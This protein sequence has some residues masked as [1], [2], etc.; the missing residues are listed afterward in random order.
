MERTGQ[1][2][3][4]PSTSGPTGPESPVGPP[5]HRGDLHPGAGPGGPV[6]V[7]RPWYRRLAWVWVLVGGVAAYLAELVMLVGTGNPNFFPSLLLL[8]ALVVPLTVLTFAATG[9]RRV[10]AP[11]GWV[12]ATVL[13]GGVLGTLAAGLLEYDTLARLHAGQF[14]AVGLIEEAAKLVVPLV[15][16]ALLV[17]RYPYAGV[18]IGVASGMGFATLETMGY[19][20]TALLQAH[21]LA[22]VDQ[23]LLLRAVLSPAGHVA[24]TGITV[25]ALW[26][27]PR[28]THRLRAAAL[29]AATFVATV[30]LHATWDGAGSQ[31]LRILV[32][33]VSVAAL[34]WTI[35]RV[36]RDELR[37]RT[38]RL[39]A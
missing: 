27:I 14:L 33:V 23:T 36:H 22:A 35:H 34:L 18:V 29:A 31:T 16:M 11:T 21:S 13:A 4:S 19:G 28:A 6:P 8:G 26:R 15:A 12:V 30:L 32:G 39:Q 2:L 7:Q 3:T 37:T 25:A 5:P 24:W 9:G 10:T 38:E 17:R 1:S 20:F